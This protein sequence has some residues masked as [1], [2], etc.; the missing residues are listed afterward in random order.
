MLGE[1]ELSGK[2]LPSGEGDRYPLTHPSKP[3]PRE[4]G[5]REEG[6][7]ISPWTDGLSREAARRQA[8][9]EREF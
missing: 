5:D 2:G 6:A 7:K 3:Q 1:D 4:T 9:K 8:D